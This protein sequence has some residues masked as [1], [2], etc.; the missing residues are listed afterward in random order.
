MV[1]S[2]SPDMPESPVGYIRLLTAVH[3]MCDDAVVGTASVH[4]AERTF[5]AYRLILP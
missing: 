5:A 3:D 4:G 1:L 2:T